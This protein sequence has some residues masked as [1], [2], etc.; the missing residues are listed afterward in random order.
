MFLN[1]L[2]KSGKCC[3]SQSTQV[4]PLLAGLLAVLC[5]S[6][7]GAQY[8]GVE[9]RYHALN[10]QTHPGVPGYWSA[11]LNPGSVNYYQ[12]VQVELP[13]KGQV[14][15]F[16]G[17]A[18]KP[19][20][21]PA[22]AMAGVAVGNIY[23]LRLSEMPEYPGVELYPSIEIV[24]RLHP[25]AGK[26]FE[27]PVPIQIT[28]DE[29]DLAL[30]GNLVTKVIYLEQPQLAVPRLQT[31]LEGPT[32]LAAD[33]NAIAEADRRG[34]PMVILR[35]GGRVPSQQ[36]GDRDF[37]GTGARVTLPPKPAVSMPERS[38]QNRNAGLP[39][40]SVNR[41]RSASSPSEQAI[42]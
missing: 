27:F 16:S 41:L 20:A 4:L 31:G 38:G 30:A 18:R 35:I 33:R 19:V 42:D 32:A 26:I 21:Q 13:T 1:R 40:E 8:K 25:P 10:Q 29:I 6:T 36:P 11:I 37:F 12:P 28:A 24:D 34:R 23:R 5:C 15:F 7:A 14:A 22:P 2:F 3:R 39:R 9:G 17:P